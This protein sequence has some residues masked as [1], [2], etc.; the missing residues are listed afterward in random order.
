MSLVFSLCALLLLDYKRQLA[1]FWRP[2][3][4]G[5]ITLISVVFFLSWDVAG[6]TLGIFSTNQE[7][8]SGVYFITPNLPL[9]ELL[10][11]TLLAYQTILLW[12]WQ[13]G[14]SEPSL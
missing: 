10:F 5:L 2:K 14:E 6:I 1:F 8:V 3:K 9:E 4:V 11:L 13:D 12:R 7:W